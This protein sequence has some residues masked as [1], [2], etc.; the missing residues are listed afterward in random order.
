M[1]VFLKPFSRSDPD[2]GINRRLLTTPDAGALLRNMVN[3]LF[4]GVGEATAPPNH[5]AASRDWSPTPMSQRQK[6][7]RWMSLGNKEGC[8]RCDGISQE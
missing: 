5:P 3:S 2:F 4:T 6:E 1:S 8:Q 7:A